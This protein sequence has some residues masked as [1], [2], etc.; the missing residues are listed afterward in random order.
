MNKSL[1]AL[2]IIIFFS[3]EDYAQNLPDSGSENIYREAA[4]R[5]NDLVHT[6]LEVRFDYSKSYMYGKAWL[7]L[8]PHFY[9]TD[10]L[11]LDAKGMDIN[12]ISLFNKNGMTALKYDYDGM[13]LNIHLNRI[14]K[15]GELYT[16]FIDYTAKPN[17]LKVKGSAAINDAKGLYFINPKGEDKDTP[18]QIWTQGETE[19]TSAWCPTIDKPN[20]KSTQEI[21]M[22]VPNKYVTLSNGKLVSQKKNADGTR[23]DYWNMDQPHAPYLF[24][25]GVGDYAIIKDTY[26]GK[27]VNYYVEKQFGPVARKIFGNTPEMM[28]FFGKI[29]GVD[30]PWVKYSQ[31]VGRDYV[32]GAMENTT[33]TLHQ[34]NAQ[35]DARELV[36]GN[37]WES[38]I[39]HELFH[40]WFGDLVTAESWSNLTLNESFANYSETLWD[41]YKYGKDAGDA[42]NFIDMQGYLG[43]RSGSK[44]L[45]RFNYADKEEMFDAVSYNKGGRILHMLRNFLG[46]SAFFKGLNVYLTTNK[47]KS[48]EAQQLRLAFEEVSGRDLNWFF[49]Q[50]YYGSGN[51][52][53]DINY[54]YDENAR[55]VSVIIKQTQ[56]GN[57]AFKLPIAIDIYNGPDKVR[58]NVWLKEKE[59]T[60]IF[61]YRTKPDL[62][63]VD[64]DKVL[65]CDKKDNK[66]LDNF[67]HQYKFAGNYMDRREA[68][69][70]C[71]KLQDDL[72]AISLIKL[73]T[74]D[75]FYGLREHTLESLDL[76][77]PQLREAME[78][79]I[80]EIAKNEK[81]P[82][83]RAKAISLLGSYPNKPEYK[84][85]FAKALNDSSY[86]VSGAA[87]EAIT[88]SD[89]AASLEEV[90]KL[91]NKPA[92]GKLAESITQLL[93]EG[94]AESDFDIIADNFGKMP[95]GDAKFEALQPFAQYLGKVIITEKF[96]K[97]VDLITSFRDGIPANYQSQTTPFINNVVLRSIVSQKTSA[98]K[99]S[100][101]G[102]I[103][104]QLDYLKAQITDKKGF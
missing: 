93:M 88:I 95:F 80:Y 76:K 101:A 41:E 64:G 45:V 10:S 9:A 47:F 100:D 81:K 79:I 40:Q 73:A 62:V 92:K 4:T 49:N 61:D 28:A 74:E 18:T 52:S 16:L 77:K 37:K 69:D 91:K 35:Q 53:L 24:F 83:V 34:E 31:I 86:S 99:G 102:N 63:N 60:F 55:K 39:A 19:A 46:D 51:P 89:H 17:E 96:K 84:S 42:Q 58:H 59:Q 72:R 75:K 11:V 29:T 94:G 27:E 85:L 50:W 7:T 66:T 25:M 23:T 13:I 5:V 82:T 6:K 14:Y 3:L 103:Q 43:S 67:I 104:Q 57:Q 36:D 78:S 21:Y 33:A 38:T 98:L 32:S 26:K 15:G 68:I 2:L 1:C 71:A 48:A 30:Y 8:K 44:D 22:T 20:Q 65:L 70:F 90:N 12:K 54:V 87:L 97:G 56:A